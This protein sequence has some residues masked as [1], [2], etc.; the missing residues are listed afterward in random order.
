MDRLLSDGIDVVFDVYDLNEGDDKFVFMESMATDDTVSHVLI[1][2][3]KGYS[4]KANAREA[5]V[6]TESQIISENIYN[7]VKQSKF[8]SIACE[9]DEHGS[10]YLPTFFKSRI[11]I[12][13]FL[14]RISKRQLGAYD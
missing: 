6:G 2:C 13:F 10:P 8:I 4:E 3:D 7:K 5:G 14:P 11:F 9:L 1:F 12:D